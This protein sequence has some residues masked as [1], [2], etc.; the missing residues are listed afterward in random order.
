MCH[1][2]VLTTHTQGLADRR[3]GPRDIYHSCDTAYVFIQHSAL[4]SVPPMHALLRHLHKQAPAQA[5]WPNVLRRLPTPACKLALLMLIK[6][7]LDSSTSS[8]CQSHW[9]LDRHVPLVPACH[10][11]VLPALAQRPT[12]QAATSTQA[13][14]G[15]VR[16]LCLA[17]AHG[18]LQLLSNSSNRPHKVTCFRQPQRLVPVLATFPPL[19]PSAADNAHHTPPDHH[20]AAACMQ[21]TQQ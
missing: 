9:V 8:C 7:C 11:A 19:G 20:Q 17:D 15:C 13:W 3:R 4:C 6:A 1:A 14:Q 21:E 12:P 10:S 18:T 2:T 5:F 16:T